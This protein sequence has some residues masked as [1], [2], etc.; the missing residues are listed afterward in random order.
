MIKIKK[1]S[2]FTKTCLII[3]S[4]GN[5][6]A[7]VSSQDAGSLIMMISF[8][9]NFKCLKVNEDFENSNHIFRIRLRFL[10]SNQDL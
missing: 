10:E 7:V 5:L 2:K 9:M 6:C 3:S 4:K 8:K 1:H